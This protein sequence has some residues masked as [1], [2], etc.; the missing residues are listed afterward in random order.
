MKVS[1]LMQ[2]KELIPSYE[3][4]V[5]NDDFV[6]AIKTAAEQATEKDYIV[7]QGGITSHAASINSETSESQYIRTG[8]STTRTDAQRQFSITGDRYCAD[9]AQEFLLSNKMKFATG[10]GATVPYIYF[11]IFTGVGEKGTVTVDVTEDQGGEA[12]GN[13]SFSINL[14]GTAKPVDYKYTQG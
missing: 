13:A 1:E 11:N 2:G 5:T 8:K 14:M 6:L 12:G 4:V 10:K 7:I 3:G 9:D